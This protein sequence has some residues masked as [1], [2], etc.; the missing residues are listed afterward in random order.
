MNIAYFL[1]L[2]W[3]NLT[4][5]PE[6]ENIDIKQS[7]K[8]SLYIINNWNT[9]FY[10]SFFLL[11]ASPCHVIC[12]FCTVKEQKDRT[13]YWDHHRKIADERLK[14]RYPHYKHFTWPPLDSSHRLTLYRPAT[15]QGLTY[16]CNAGGHQGAPEMFQLQ[17]LSCLLFLTLKS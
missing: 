10:L 9:L 12:Y 17:E 1:S 15:N 13:Y 3:S 4:C 16:T 2:F 14:S 7:V 6:S 8:Y 5:W 11:R